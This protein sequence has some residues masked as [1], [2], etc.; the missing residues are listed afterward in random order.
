MIGERTRNEVWQ[1]LWD[2]HRM[3]RYYQAVHK[4]NQRWNRI[5][6]VGV[7]VLRHQCPGDDLGGR[8]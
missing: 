4:G 2:A 3:V 8:A 1:G 6:H 7:G 5:N